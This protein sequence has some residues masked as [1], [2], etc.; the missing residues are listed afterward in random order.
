MKPTRHIS[1]ME[2]CSMKYTATDKT[3]KEKTKSKNIKTR[4][5]PGYHLSLGIVITMLSVIVL[6]PLA[7]V[8]VYSLKISPGD[9]VA[10]IMKECLYHKH[11]LIIYRSNRKCGIWT[12]RGMDAC[13]VRF[14]REMAA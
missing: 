12:H 14:S 10:L 5:I 13:E 2:Q 8:L 11:H 1:M 4:V 7:S 6:I 9:F 3:A